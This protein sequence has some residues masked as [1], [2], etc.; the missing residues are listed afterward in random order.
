LC[1]GQPAVNAAGR[2][3]DLQGNTPP[4]FQTAQVA[5]VRLGQFAAA[6][7]YKLARN[8]HSSAIWVGLTHVD[9]FAQSLLSQP[10]IQS[11]HERHPDDDSEKR[12][13]EG[14]W[15][16]EVISVRNGR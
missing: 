7:D 12:I 8:R 9:F 15:R 10:K 5:P 1:A 13:A 3:E 4:V 16:E 2:P 6:S 11:R 14:R